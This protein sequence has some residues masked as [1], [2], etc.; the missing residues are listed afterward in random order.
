MLPFCSFCP[1]FYLFVRGN[2]CRGDSREHCLGPEAE[3][4]TVVPAAREQPEQSASEPVEQAKLPVAVLESVVKVVAAAPEAVMTSP[5][6]PPIIAM[7]L[8]SLSGSSAMASFAD[9]ELAKFEAMDLD[10]Q[11]DRLEML[12]S[13]V[14]KAKS[15]AVEE[16]MERL[17][18][19]QSTELD[20]DREAIDQLMKDLDLLHRQNMAPKPILEMSI[21][22]ARDVH[23]LHD[24][25]EDLKPTVKTSE[26]CKATHEANLA[27]FAKQKAELDQ[28]AELQK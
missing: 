23:N 28:I 5:L 25:Y 27:D 4:S 7:P 17:K 12:S 2:P 20:K 24:R 22:L 14:G 21:G 18:I 19:W 8:H 16:A 9:P 1:D 13:L 6:K 10:A 11:L 3:H 15:K 26:F